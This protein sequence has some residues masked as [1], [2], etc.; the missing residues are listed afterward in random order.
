MT[1]VLLPRSLDRL[2]SDLAAHPEATLM[3]GGT[4]LLV[5]RRSGLAAPKTIICLERIDKLKRLESDGDGLFIG[6]GLSHHRLAADPLIQERCPV[7]AQAAGQVGSPAIRHMGTLGGNLATASPA[8]DTLPP[9]YILEAEVELAAAGGSR[10][11]AVDRFI[12]GPGKTD[13]RPSEVIMGV[14]LPSAQRFGIQHYEKVGRRQALAISLVSLAALIRLD[15][16][17][18]AEA[19]LAWGSVGPTVIR[20]GEA[21]AALIGREMT[22]ATF[23]ELEPVFRS[24]VNPIDDL[25]ATADYRRLVAA[26]L[27]GRLAEGQP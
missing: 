22:E 26:R 3:A 2:W 27:P 21:E 7:L 20:S 5:R 18:I 23:S 9:L 11:L 10:R 13:L 12:A 14:H 17:T 19:R 24:A 15:R 6:S 4:D 25:R 8:G 1:E 16:G